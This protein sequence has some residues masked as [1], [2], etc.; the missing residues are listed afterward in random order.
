MIWKKEGKTSK[1]LYDDMALYST[2]Y[3][4]Q[5]SYIHVMILE[6]KII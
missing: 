1:I 6:G 4:L 5:T 3:Q 2:S